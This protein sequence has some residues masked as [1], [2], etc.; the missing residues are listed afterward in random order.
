MD[1]PCTSF[2]DPPFACPP[3]VVIDL[4]YPPSV[5]RLWRATAAHG[6]QSV[7]LAPSYVN[8]KK[9]ADDLLMTYRS[10]RAPTI[11]GSFS[12]A[13]GLCPP[14]G[15]KRGDIDNRVKAV[16]DFMQRVAVIENDKHCQR[17][18]VEWVESVS[19]PHGCRVTVKACA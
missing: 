6:E 15:H 13:I 11:R 19:A 12:I 9:S 10:W 16:L 18:L 3:D 4:P 1:A 14:K 7:Y 5:N 2:A 8:W 17:L